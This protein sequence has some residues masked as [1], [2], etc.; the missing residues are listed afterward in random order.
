MIAQDIRELEYESMKVKTYVDKRIA[1]YEKIEFKDI[2][3]YQ[4]LYDAIEHLGQLHCKYYG[5]FRLWGKAN[6]VPIKQYDWTVIF[7]HPWI[8]HSNSW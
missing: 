5:L 3:S 1:H 6:L 8:D 2:P 7:H 4:E